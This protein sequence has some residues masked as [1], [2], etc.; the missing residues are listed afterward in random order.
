MRWLLSLFSIALLSYSI[1]AQ[2]S[3]LFPVNRNGKAGYINHDG[4]VVIPLKFDEVWPFT[5]GLAPVRVRDDWGYIDT[6]GDFV[7]K[8]QFFEPGLFA[9]GRAHVGIY[10][11]GRKIIDSMVGEYAYIDRSGRILKRQMSRDPEFFSGRGMFQTHGNMSDSRTGYVD[12][13][14]KVVIKPTFVYGREFSEGLACVMNDH[15]RA[16]FI[17]IHGEVQV[18]FE[19]EQCGSFSEGVGAVLANDLVGFV[20]RSGKMVIPPQFSW[21]IGDETRFSDGVAV[22]Q[23]G[24]GEKPTNN[25]VR[26]VTMAEGSILAKMSGLFGVIDKTGKFII[27]P[28]YV[29]I[30]DF[31]NGLAWVN[32]GDSYIIHGD[33][34]RWGYINKEGKIVW[35]SF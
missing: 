17:D 16:G 35:K 6:N 13:S 31:H 18:P 33:T 34:N 30:G 27:A 7:I 22:V 14:G 10:W 26:D 25:E 5:E 23:V 21:V 1:Y 8:P 4:Q 9:G 28:R 20:D 12:E 29:Q 24:E 19:Y 15:D 3:S 11:K 2:E 32:L